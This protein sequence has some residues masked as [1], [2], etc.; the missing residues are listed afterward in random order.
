ML[1][2]LGRALFDPRQFFGSLR[3]E[4]PRTGRAFLAL[5]IPTALGSLLLLTRADAVVAQA[6]PFAR[7]LPPEVLRSAFYVGSVL[8]APLGALLLWASGWLPI[9]IGSGRFARISEVAAWT[10]LPAAATSLLANAAGTIAALPPPLLLG[11]QMAGIAWC[12]W[13]VY[14]GLRAFHPQRVRGGV[15]AYALFALGALA[16][17]LGGLP[18][19]SPSPDGLAF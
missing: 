3:G 9:R 4:A 2:D 11:V 16:L 6:L 14:E 15:L 7:D 19:A 10:Q 18:G 1:R 17:G 12:G 8:G 13:L 5:L